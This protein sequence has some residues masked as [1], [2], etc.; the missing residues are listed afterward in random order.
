MEQL[1]RNPLAGQPCN[2]PHKNKNSCVR[3]PFTK[4][5]AEARKYMERMQFLNYRGKPRTSK[6]RK[7]QPWI[8]EGKAEAKSHVH[9]TGRFAICFPGL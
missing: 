9:R 7:I 1:N 4:V 2:T 5:W 6:M 8:T 3:T